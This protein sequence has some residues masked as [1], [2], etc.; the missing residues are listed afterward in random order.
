[1]TVSSFRRVDAM[2]MPK[3]L[4]R[5]LIFSRSFHGR[6]TID[7]RSRDRGAAANH[8]VAL[9]LLIAFTVGENPAR[10]ASNDEASG[11]LRNMAM[12]PTAHFA[13]RLSKA[14]EHVF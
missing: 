10:A 4:R 1:M 7:P 8:E 14:T 9:A 13:R 11:M 3:P 2:Q 6:A 12:L 5:D